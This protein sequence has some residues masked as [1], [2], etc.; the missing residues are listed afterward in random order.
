MKVNF[1]HSNRPLPYHLLAISIFRVMSLYAYNIEQVAFASTLRAYAFFLIAA[2]ILFVIA[3]VT[4]RRLHLAAM[5]VSFG[6]LLSH[7]LV[8][9]QTFL[10]G[11]G[12]EDISRARYL[13]PLFAFIFVGGIGW[14]IRKI[15][16][17]EVWANTINVMALSALIF[18]LF[19]IGRH[20]GSLITSTN[21]RQVANPK[22]TSVLA[23]VDRSKKLPDI[24]LI[25]LDTHG[26]SDDTK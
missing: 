10:T 3:F 7:L 11:H 23:T 22:D 4:I 16:N 14:G 8:P 21:T 18:P 20:V 6:F 17:P 5:F 1:T 19:L 25:V 9:L 13:L 26:S 12:M 15:K 24:Y 2:V